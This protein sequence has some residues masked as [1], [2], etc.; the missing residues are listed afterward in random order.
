MIDVEPLLDDGRQQ[1]GLYT[2]VGRAG[3]LKLT[4]SHG[5]QKISPV[6]CGYGGCIIGL[7]SA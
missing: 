5:S 3:S 1:R 4:A 7:R 2:L 6:V